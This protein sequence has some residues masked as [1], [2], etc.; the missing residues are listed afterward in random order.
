MILVKA[1]YLVQPKKSVKTRDY[2]GEGKLTNSAQIN[3]DQKSWLRP[4]FYFSLDTTTSD[5]G[6][7][8]TIGDLGV[9]KL[10]SGL[11]N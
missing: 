6:V 5:L 4:V 3:Y 1:C 11:A 10:S 9:S 8:K 2:F 7:S